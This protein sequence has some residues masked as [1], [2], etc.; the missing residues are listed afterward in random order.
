MGQVSSVAKEGR[1]LFRNT[2]ASFGE[3][4][5]RWASVVA[6]GSAV[7]VAIEG[8][9]WAA[10]VTGG[11]RDA[12]T[13]IDSVGD[14]VPVQVC[15]GGWATVPRRFAVVAWTP[16]ARIG[17]PVAIRVVPVRGAPPSVGEAWM[18]RALVHM[19]G[20]AVGI[21]VPVGVEI[22]THFGLASRPSIA[23]C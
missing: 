15:P 18:P 3:A 8:H 9:R 2:A 6:I 11:A 17:D 22:S 10:A 5:N 13:S 21:G 4:H 23:R 20:N 19:V 7:P 1:K 12:R 16:V 14:P